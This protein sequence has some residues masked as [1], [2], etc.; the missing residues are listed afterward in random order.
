[1]LRGLSILFCLALAANALV[2]QN[3][4]IAPYSGCIGGDSGGASSVNY[5]KNSRVVS[6]DDFRNR[7]FLRTTLDKTHLFE[8]ELVQVKWVLYYPNCPNL[9]VDYQIL[10]YQIPSLPDFI[11]E[12]NIIVKENDS[13]AFSSLSLNGL[14]YRARTLLCFYMYPSKIGDAS[15]GSGQ[16]SLQ[17]YGENSQK[18]GEPFLLT[19]KPVAVNVRQLP[20]KNESFT[21]G[22]GEFKLETE[23]LRPDSIFVDEAATFRIR[24]KG[25]GNFGFLDV[26]KPIFPDFVECYQSKPVNSISYNCKQCCGER[27][28]DF[29][30]IPHQSGVFSIPSVC[31]S[32]FNTRSRCF[33]LLKTA[34]VKVS[35]LKALPQTKTKLPVLSTTDDDSKTELCPFVLCGLLLA[36]CVVGF[37]VWIIRRGKTFVNFEIQAYDA[38]NEAKENLKGDQLFNTYVKIL[39]T[40]IGN[41][42]NYPVATQSKSVLADILRENGAS[43][44]S[45]S[46]VLNV[47]SECENACYTPFY[48]DKQQNVYKTAVFA[49]TQLQQDFSET[50]RCSSIS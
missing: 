7:L 27:I 25:S 23:L 29:V 43:D 3:F 41:K 36:S 30:F 4:P 42:L 10:D 21:G 33:Q 20:D 8:N 15:V 28:F 46:L 48:D 11:K 14:Q 18:Y 1:M 37:V 31:F 24:V 6:I 50:V 22:I 9:K 47:I 39:I 38:L 35:V 34:P 49:I 16:I 26:P 19:S 12:W 2:A 44:A 45:V 40:Y 5:G 17:L 32:Y 13:T